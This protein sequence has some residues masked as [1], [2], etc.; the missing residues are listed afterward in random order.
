AEVAQSNGLPELYPD[1]LKADYRALESFQ[2]HNFVWLLRSC[3]TVLLPIGIGVNPVF[4]DYWLESKHGQR[5][6]HFFLDTDQRAKQIVRGITG[7]EASLLANQ[8]P[9]MRRGVDIQT[10]AED[11]NDV[12]KRGCHLGI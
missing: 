11:V 8:A 2:G 12:L 10:F 6:M 9:T 3:G 5:I 1:D 4:I 7:E